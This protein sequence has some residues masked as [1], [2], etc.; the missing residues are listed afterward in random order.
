[1]RRLSV[2]AASI[3]I[4][5]CVGF[6]TAAEENWPQWRGPLGTGV[7]AEGQYPVKFSSEEGI[8][9]K[10]KLP[11]SGSST[12]AVWGARIFVTCQIEGQDGLVC[13]DM[14]GQ[15][16]WQRKFGLGREGKKARV[17]TGS[18][19]SPVTDGTHVVAYYKSGMLACT[20]LGGR[21]IWKHNLQ[22]QYG[23][24]TLWWDLGTSPVLV[25]GKAV[26]AVMHEGP[27]YL[28]A[29]DLESG[30]EV[31]KQ[32]RDYENE[33]ESD[34]AY[35]T[36]QVVQ[37]DGKDVIVTWGADHLTGHDAATGKL[38]WESSGFNPENRGMWRVIAS[39]PIEDGVAIVP[40]GRGEFLA[41]V[42]V[43]GEG[44]V[45]KSNRVWEKQGR[46][47][48]VDVPTPVVADGK[49]YLLSDSGRITCR[50][51]RSGEEIW[52][53]DLP[54]NRN[55]Y[56]A[57]PVLAGDLLY[58]TREDGTIFV[59]RVTEDGFEQLAENPMGEWTI[60]TP[61]PIRGGLLI[62]GEE[63]L[64]RIGPSNTTAAPRAG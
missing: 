56:Y 6:T 28:V 63:H 43:A 57:S 53:F 64:F 1:M 46:G 61:I 52:S 14:N 26:V 13:Y 62:R 32:E 40:Y 19:P 35:T 12:P 22:E 33:R 48:G 55:K 9:W 24:D 25:G 59:G 41:A 31:W 34:Q 30:E 16:Q 50:D 21:E 4:S 10:V 11:G 29:F 58:C 17:G 18:N 45:T 20:E 39:A 37:Q 51:I 38:L 2:I 3:I 36:P 47:L 8:A 49:A 5:T 42:R 44:D 7:A 27:S 15:E 23:E 60:A 54:R